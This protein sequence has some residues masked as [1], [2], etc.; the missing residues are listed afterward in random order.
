MFTL[1]LTYEVYSFL[2]GTKDK[3]ETLANC[4]DMVDKN[5]SDALGIDKMKDRLNKEV[6]DF[7][8][9]LN[10]LLNIVK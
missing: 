9:D 10:K 3:E 7:K 8:E 2:D 1:S 6:N 5:R 4:R